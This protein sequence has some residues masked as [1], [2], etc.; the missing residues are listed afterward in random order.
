MADLIGRVSG[1]GRGVEAMHVVD[2]SI[3]VVVHPVSRDL[4]GVGPQIGG[5][6]GVG[7]ADSGIDHGHDHGCRVVDDVPGPHGVD[8]GAL[9]AA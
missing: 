1:L 2:D 7:Q 6:V 9:E 8:V 4:A 3:P 5:E